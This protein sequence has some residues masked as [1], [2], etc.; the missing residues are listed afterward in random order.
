MG[1]AGHRNAVPALATVSFIESSIFPIPPDIMLIP[2]VLANKTRAFRLA[3]ICTVAS[4]FGGLL[5]YV[6]GVF[7][8]DEIGRPLL[9]F[10]GFASKFEEFQVKY[11]DWGAWAVFVAGITP[12]PYKVITIL[13]GVTSLNLTIFITASLAARGLRFFIVAGLLWKFGDPI[14]T[15]I[16][17]YLSLLFILLSALLVGGFIAIKLFI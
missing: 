10:Y 3:F 16:E 8:F 13:S 14:R 17:K 15:L 7:L 6:I 9:E 1:L 4:V 12:F 5:G 11:N 2:M